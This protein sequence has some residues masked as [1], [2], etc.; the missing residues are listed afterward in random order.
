MIITQ[1]NKTRIIES[2]GEAEAEI[3]RVLAEKFPDELLQIP[4][5][6]TALASL[7]INQLDDSE[8]SCADVDDPAALIENAIS[9]NKENL[10]NKVSL[11]RPTSMIM[12]LRSIEYIADNIK[13]FRVLSVGPRTEAEIYTLVACGFAPENI[14][15]LDLISYSD[16]IDVGDMHAMPYDD[17]SFDIVILGF[18]LAYS[19]DNPKAVNEVLRVLRPG[20]IVVVGC[21]YTPYTREELENQGS[22]VS[23]G[24]LFK[25]TE[26]IVDLFGDTVD[27]VYFRNDVHP[28]M[29]HKPGG[30]III[31]SLKP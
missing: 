7:R 16:F 24:V 15:G 11:F 31:F 26:E 30:L 18:V 19:N 28:S 22:P 27:Q 21:E 20:G 13:E 4:F 9:Y 6:R 25:S 2:V 12:P 1:Q 29:Q 17:D 5:M 23:D 8:I 14:R 10:L 3:L